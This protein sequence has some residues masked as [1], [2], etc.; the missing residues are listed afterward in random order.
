[1]AVVWIIVGTLYTVGT[2]TA[3]VYCKSKKDTKMD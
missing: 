1:M 3:I 2:L